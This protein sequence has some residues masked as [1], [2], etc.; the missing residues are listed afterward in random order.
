MTL[1]G[2]LL[3]IILFSKCARPC[4]FELRGHV[5]GTSLLLTPRSALAPR[6]ASLLAPTLVFRSPFSP[7]PR[8]HRILEDDLLQIAPRKAPPIHN[9][10][11]KV[12]PLKAARVQVPLGYLRL[13]EVGVVERGALEDDAGEVHAARVAVAEVALAEVE[14]GVA[15]GVGLACDLLYVSMRKEH[16]L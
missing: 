7:R 11:R 5:Y 9:S 4:Q 1:D 2:V 12:R 15:G 10:V 16:F 3:Y 14:Q 6:F 13:R 8:Q